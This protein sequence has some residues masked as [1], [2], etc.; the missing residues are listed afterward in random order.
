MNGLERAL[1]LS[2]K[3]TMYTKQINV[4]GISYPYYVSRCGSIFNSSGK[5]LSES[6]AGSTKKYKCVHLYP[7]GPLPKNKR[8]KVVYV[9]QAVLHSYNS[10]ENFIKN[11]FSENWDNFSEEDKESLL[12]LG[13]HGLV[14]DHIDGDHL[15]NNIENLR[16]TTRSENHPIIK[17][18]SNLDFYDVQNSYGR[19]EKVHNDF[20]TPVMDNTIFSRYAINKNG[21]CFV[22]KTGK[23]L[24]RQNRGKYQYYSMDCEIA[25]NSEIQFSRRTGNNPRLSQRCMAIH[26]LVKSTFDP[27]YPKIQKKFSNV[28]N[29]LNEDGKKYIFRLG[30]SCYVIDHVDGNRKNNNL[31]NLQYVTNQENQNRKDPEYRKMRILSEQI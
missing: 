3:K 31:S 24:T 15:N 9:H 10:A 2:P 27:I 30:R 16:W 4:N 13:R 21:D 18:Y 6:Y 19:S 1:G 5:K 28:L 12:F 26:Q 14:I 23:F 11:I 8:R 7:P 20:S 22:I 25:E 17:N 29:L